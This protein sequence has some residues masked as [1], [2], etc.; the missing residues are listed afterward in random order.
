MLPALWNRAL[1]HGRDR[2]GSP[3]R[4]A[5]ACTALS[6]WA[7][8]NTHAPPSRPLPMQRPH[9]Q[10]VARSQTGER[11][12]HHPPDAGSAP[13]CGRLRRW[14]RALS[15]ERRPADARGLSRSIQCG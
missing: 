10:A 4:S 9:R 6:G 1:A 2:H 15:R 7:A 12:R 13:D 11:D 14:P 8:M 3:V 5:R